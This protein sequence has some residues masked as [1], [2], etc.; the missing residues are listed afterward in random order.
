LSNEFAAEFPSGDAAST[1]CAQGLI[2]AATTFTNADT[3][4]L[5]RHGL[6]IAARIL[7][8]TLEGAGEPLPASELAD[9][10]LVTG[11]SITSLV[12]TLEGKGYLRRVRSESDRRVVLVELTDR[13][14]PVVDEYLAEVTTLHAAEFAIFSERERRQLAR[15]LHRLA[16]HI[17]TLDVDAVVAQARPRNRPAR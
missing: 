16:D 13:A 11:P 5:R 12:D 15:L 8:A 2:R 6:S 14:R 10:L 7:L 4:G 1:E 9:R 17:A 3:R